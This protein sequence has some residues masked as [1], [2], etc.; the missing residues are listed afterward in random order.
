MTLWE[1]ERFL[2]RT[3][4]ENEETGDEGNRSLRDPWSGSVVEIET[5]FDSRVLLDTIMLKGGE[6]GVLFNNVATFYNMN[7]AWWKKWE[8]VFY[9]WWIVTDKEYEP[10]WD[11][12]G[13]EEIKDR[14]KFKGTLAN[15]GNE[16][17]SEKS[18]GSNSIEENTENKNS[19]EKSHKAINDDLEHSKEKINRDIDETQSGSKTTLVDN[20]D[21]EHHKGE[22][23]FD[24][25][26]TYG[27]TVVQNRVSAYDDPNLVVH[28]EQTIKD[29]VASYNDTPAKDSASK[30]VDRNYGSLTKETFGEKNSP[31]KTNI[32]DKTNETT[33]DITK[34]NHF[35][36]AEVGG[37]SSKGGTKNKQHSNNDSSY[38]LEN[39]N[40]Q[41][42]ENDRNFDHAM[43]QWGNFGVLTTSQVLLKQEFEARFHTNPYE[44]MS[45]I[46]I[47]E[48]TD[49]VWV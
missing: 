38:F 14:S 17:K 30:H 7:E 10:L 33:D 2:N 18:V 49:G 27:N 20:P 32:K 5:S 8:G 44:L 37:D 34:K 31:Y 47:K 48:M 1:V 43:H 41:Y 29:G 11:R 24:N 36:E 16:A 25:T 39:E 3:H 40:E 12:N 26:Q 4:W 19:Y 35:V 28:D 9:K 13:F 46:Y 42:N 6:L 22:G 45:T 23:A 21:Q 15:K